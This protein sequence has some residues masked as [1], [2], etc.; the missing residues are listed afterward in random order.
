[1]ALLGF[2]GET[3]TLLNTVAKFAEQFFA[4]GNFLCNLIYNIAAGT[5]VILRSLSHQIVFS[6]GFS[7][8]VLIGFFLVSLIFLSRFVTRLN[9]S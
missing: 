4:V 5:A 8:A 9:R 7:F 2:G 3:R 1:L 6:F